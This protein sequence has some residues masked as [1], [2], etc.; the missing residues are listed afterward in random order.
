MKIK[1]KLPYIRINIEDEK[2][3]TDVSLIVDSEEFLNEI[4]KLRND[5]ETKF[6]LI[7]PTTPEKYEDFETSIFGK[8]EQQEYEAM[9]EIVRNKLYLPITFLSVIGTATIF[10][11]VDSNAYKPAYLEHETKLFNDADQTPDE[12]YF[13]TLSPSARDTDVLQAFQ[14]YR[15]KLGNFKGVPKYKY[16]HLIWKPEKAKPAIKHYREWFVKYNSGMSAK[17]IEEEMYGNCKITER[18]TTKP[19]PKGCTCYD[20]STIRKEISSYQALI[21]KIWKSRTF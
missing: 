20:E 9:F 3:F 21:Y 6:K 15:D 11:E 12:R 18:H 10:G 2:L 14:E 19:R 4:L 7:L 13:I 8:K 17:E 1:K 5:I 16:I